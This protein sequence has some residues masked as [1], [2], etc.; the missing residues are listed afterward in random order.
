VIETDGSCAGID[1]ATV[2]TVR[3]VETTRRQERRRAAAQRARRRIAWGGLGALVV[4]ALLLAVGGQ[5][6]AA[7]VV[8]GCALLAFTIA[9]IF[10]ATQPEPEMVVR[11]GF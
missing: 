2:G 4:V 9:R 7:L 8:A 11:R 3:S 5:A 6:G 10:V 1:A